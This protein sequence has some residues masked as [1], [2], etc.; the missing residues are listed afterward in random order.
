MRAD[1]S[2]YQSG[3]DAPLR[4]AVMSLSTLPSSEGVY[5]GSKVASQTT[6]TLVTLL[7]VLD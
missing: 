3:G 7:N 6:N 5:V 1:V 4:E 2:S